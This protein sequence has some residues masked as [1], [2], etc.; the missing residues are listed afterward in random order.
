MHRDSACAN[1]RRHV[2]R[3]LRKYGYSPDLQDAAVQNVLQQTALSAEWAAKRSR[4]KKVSFATQKQVSLPSVLA[5]TFPAPPIHSDR[6]RRNW[7]LVIANV[8]A[9]SDELDRTFVS[10]IVGT[11]SAT[12]AWFESGC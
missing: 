11:V 2:K 6:R 9:V 8:A 4:S 5:S 7:E 1:I 12:A 10:E 3:L